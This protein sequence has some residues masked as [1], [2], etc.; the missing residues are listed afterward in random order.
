MIPNTT[1]V[2][3]KNKQIKGKFHPEKDGWNWCVKDDRIC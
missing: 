3:T 1:F 2:S